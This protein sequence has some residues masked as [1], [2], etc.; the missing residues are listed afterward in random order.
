MTARDLVTSKGH[1]QPTHAKTTPKTHQ[2]KAKKNRTKKQATIIPHAT[3]SAPRTEK[4]NKENRDPNRKPHTPGNG[5]LDGQKKEREREM[6]EKEKEK[7]R[8]KRKEKKQNKQSQKKEKEDPRDPPKYPPIPDSMRLSRPLPIPSLPLPSTAESLVESAAIP[9]PSPWRLQNPSEPPSR[10]TVVLLSRERTRPKIVEIEEP[11]EA[12][13]PTELS[14]VNLRV[15]PDRKGK[16]KRYANYDVDVAAEDRIGVNNFFGAEFPR[17]SYPGSEVTKIFFVCTFHAS[18]LD[19]VECLVLLRILSPRIGN[20]GSKLRLREQPQGHVENSAPIK[21]RNIRLLFPSSRYLILG[22]GRDQ[23][24]QLG[25]W[26]YPSVPSGDRFGGKW[27]LLATVE[28]CCY[29]CSPD[30]IEGIVESAYIPIEEGWAGCWQDYR[31]HEEE[32]NQISQESA[33]VIQRDGQM[34]LS[35]LEREKFNIDNLKQTKKASYRL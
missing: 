7:K 20:I 13:I 25:P 21:L 35:C 11:V 8:E 19:A 6:E 32:T 1:T 5:S 17:P 18:F 22:A 16:A 31:S 12:P 9:A 24:E 29:Y 14:N 10:N 26:V 2:H 28:E 30:E 27:I 3:L 23:H 4:R 15:A 34:V 33:V